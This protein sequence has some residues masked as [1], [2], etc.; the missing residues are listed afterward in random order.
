MFVSPSHEGADE[1][2]HEGVKTDGE[3]VFSI[4]IGH[5]GK[6]PALDG[7]AFPGAG[8]AALD[9]GDEAFPCA[10]EAA[11]LCRFVA[12]PEPWLSASEHDLFT[13]Q[14]I[15]ADPRLIFLA[16]KTAAKGTA[17]GTSSEGR[18][19]KKSVDPLKV[20]FRERGLHQIP[21]T[22]ERHMQH[23]PA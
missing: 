23:L 17:I 11:V 13:R 20:F 5:E 2:T 9:E 1:A 15:H 22:E 18:I 21:R 10:G 14:E 7:P 3:F 12:P 6:G 16:A 4:K 8:C 19:I